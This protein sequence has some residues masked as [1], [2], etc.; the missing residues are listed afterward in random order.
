MGFFTGSCTKEIPPMYMHMQQVPKIK[1]VTLQEFID[2]Q[3]KEDSVIECDR[4]QTYRGW[5]MS[6]LR[7]RYTYCLHL[8]PYLDEFFFRFKRRHSGYQLFVRS[9]RAVALSGLAG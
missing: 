9:V 2:M 5:K 6:Q 3:V 1:C 7:P 4:Y 8:Q